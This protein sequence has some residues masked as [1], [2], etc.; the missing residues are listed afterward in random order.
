MKPFFA[1]S[2]GRG[3]RKPRSRL[4][5]HLFSLS[6]RITTLKK[7]AILRGSKKET[8]P[9]AYAGHQEEIKESFLCYPEGF[10]QRS[11]HIRKGNLSNKKTPYA[12]RFL[13]FQLNL[14]IFPVLP[15]NP[16][17]SKY[18]IFL[19]LSAFFPNNSTI[20]SCP[21][22]IFTVYFAISLISDHMKSATTFPP[23]L[24][25]TTL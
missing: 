4:H 1:A 24:I 11:T 2:A 10:S 23:I 15:Y 25:C 13:N 18:S 8:L 5:I 7:W 16:L 9:A 6:A 22:L 17:D 12:G 21:Q 14:L 19:C 20:S 3:E